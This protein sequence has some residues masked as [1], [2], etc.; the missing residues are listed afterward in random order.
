[1]LKDSTMW[2]TSWFDTPYYHILYKDRDHCDAKEFMDNITNY[3]SLENG[4]KILDLACGKG[5]H[6][7]YLNTLGFDV[8]GADL[9]KNSISY[10]SEFENK[11]LRF[12][13]HDMCK[14]YPGKFS[15]I[16]NLF[17]S[18]GY[19]DKEEDNLSTIKAIKSS[20][21][22]KGFGVIDFMNT[23][24]VL[25][26]LVPQEVKEIDG[27]T[28]NIKRF[29][30]DG[31]IYKEIKFRDNNEDFLYTERVKNITLQDFEDYFAKA[32]VDLLDVFG[33]Y[34]LQKFNK[35]TSPRLILIFK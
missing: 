6:S 25:K 8:T 17:T 26:N 34:Q 21:N 29:Y 14:P 10:A 5:R 12:K 22:E 31:H 23:T 19:F 2:Y 28:F 13:V 35:N 33:N 1:M 15:A 32:G 11:T 30:Q 27:I 4:E 18:F 20:L 9:S 3:L 24:M 7:M 16:F